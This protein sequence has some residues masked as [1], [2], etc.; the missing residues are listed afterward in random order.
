[1]PQP[2]RLRLNAVAPILPLLPIQLQPPLQ[3]ILLVRA[4]ILLPPRVA[5]IA[6]VVGALVSQRESAIEALSLYRLLAVSRRQLRNSL[7]PVPIRLLL[8]VLRL[9]SQTLGALLL[10]LSLLQEL[11]SAVIRMVLGAIV[12]AIVNVLAY[13]LLNYLPVAWNIPNLFWN[14]VVFMKMSR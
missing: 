11:P 2:P 6:T 3:V 1:M 5:P 12:R 14:K 7:K 13:L 10:R 9:Q 4:V 8:L